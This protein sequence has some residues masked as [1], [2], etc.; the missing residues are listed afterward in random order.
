MAGFLCRGKPCLN[1]RG[2]TSKNDK[3]IIM[4][5]QDLVIFIK[6]NSKTASAKFNFIS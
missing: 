1:G 2:K 4:V 3:K 5:C 6:C